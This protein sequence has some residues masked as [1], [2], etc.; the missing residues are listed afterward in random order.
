MQSGL[1]GRQFSMTKATISD[2]VRVYLLKK[3]VKQTDPNDTRK[4]FFH[5]QRKEKIIKKASLFASSIEQPI[6]QLTEEQKQ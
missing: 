1:F 6:E 2:S 4:L 5:L 3:V